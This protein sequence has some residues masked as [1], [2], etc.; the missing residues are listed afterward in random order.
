MENLIKS[1]VLI[2]IGYLNN[3]GVGY[4]LVVENTNTNEPKITKNIQKC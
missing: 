1:W 2:I 4:E 3:K